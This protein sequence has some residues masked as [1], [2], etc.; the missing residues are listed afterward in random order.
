MRL[1]RDEGAAAVE[2]ALVSVIL[3][4]LV[5]GIIEFG[6][7]FYSVQGGAAA[8]REAA[9]RAAV[10]AIKSC[11]GPATDR[12]DLTWLV[13]DVAPAVQW[14]TSG[15]AATM[16]YTDDNNDGTPDAGD[17][18]TVTIHYDINLPVLS[19]L[20]PGVHTLTDQTQTGQARIESVQTGSVM[21]CP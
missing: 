1:H 20:V 21:T 4:L 13:K 15:S 16:D 18:V 9:R 7:A 8:A 2:F 12:T 3:F 19:A 10:G 6:F 11:D 5:F 14:P 17:T